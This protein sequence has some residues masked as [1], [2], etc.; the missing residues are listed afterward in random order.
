[1]KMIFR[2][3]IVAAFLLWFLGSPA[4]AQRSNI[5]LGFGE[6]L[7]YRVHYGFINAGEATIRVADNYYNINDQYCYRMEV[8]GRSTGAF[9][10]V[11]RIRDTWAS[12]MDTASFLPQKAFRNIE[13]GKYRQRDETFF[14]YDKKIARIEEADEKTKIV[15][16]GLGRVMDMVSGYAYLRFISYDKL[17]I[18]DTIK[19]S[20]MHEDKIYKMKIVYRGKSRV[21]TKFG[22]VYAHVISPV[23]PENKLFDGENSIRVWLSD[24]G[25]KIP[26]KIQ[27]DMFVGAVEVDLKGYKNLR[28]PSTLRAADEQD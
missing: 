28:F 15:N 10:R 25:N 22:K 18:N 23:M 11:L 12:Y 7:N 17:K 20:G 5:P 9:E 1:M 8:F 2:K 6:E 4:W 16:L 24:D 19:V 13:E 14:D 27:A 21:K 3:S 26:L